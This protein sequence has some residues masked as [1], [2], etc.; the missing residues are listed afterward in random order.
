M[1]DAS[2]NEVVKSTATG[3]A[4]DKTFIIDHPIDDNKYLVHACLEGPD[5]GVYYRGKG[6]IT[7]DTSTTIELPNYVDALAYEFTIQLTTCYT[8]KE[9]QIYQSSDIEHNRFT[10]HG[11]NGKFFWLVH[12]KR[13]DIET[14]PLKTDTTVKGSAPYKW[15]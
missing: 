2:T 15:I 8:G 5:V 1:Y 12:G 14:E 3:S 11:E 7:N 9:N 10:V 6:E 13:N 4:T